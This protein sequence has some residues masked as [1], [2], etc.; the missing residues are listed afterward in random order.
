MHQT[1]RLWN[2]LKQTF[3]APK[4]K[5]DHATL[6]PHSAEANTVHLTQ[7]GSHLISIATTA[8]AIGVEAP[9]LQID[10]TLRNQLRQRCLELYI[11]G[12]SNSSDSLIV[13]LLRCE[14]TSPGGCSTTAIDALC[15]GV[16]ESYHADSH[17]SQPANAKYRQASEALLRLVNM[18]MGKAKMAHDLEDLL[19]TIRVLIEC[20]YLLPMHAAKEDLHRYCDLL[21]SILRRNNLH[22]ITL[23]MQRSWLL[24]LYYAALI[25]K[26]SLLFTSDDPSGEFPED[27]FVRQYA[28]T[29]LRL[30]EEARSST[31]SNTHSTISA[32]TLYRL[33]HRLGQLIASIKRLHLQWSSQTPLPF[34]LTS[35]K[36]FKD[37]HCFAYLDSTPFELAYRFENP[38]D[39][40]EFQASMIGVLEISQAIVHIYDTNAHLKSDP[41]CHLQFSCAKEDVRNAADTSCMLVPR[42]LEPDNGISNIISAVN[43]LHFASKIYR[44][45]GCE[46]QMAWCTQIEH[47]IRRRYGMFVNT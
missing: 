28:I 19:I 29:S 38:F 43:V 7:Q 11:G 1:N 27:S 10:A 20:T 25:A 8:T 3:P 18:T 33:L 41:V 21:I 17:H 30:L 46:Q 45:N 4:N 35:V 6:Q 2:S 44:Q 23:S 39:E 34:R 47:A 36:S 26:R 31:D 37:Y 32:I 12:R 22:T 5:Q 24:D 14:S 13:H 15:L 42:L 16:V 9:I 40:S